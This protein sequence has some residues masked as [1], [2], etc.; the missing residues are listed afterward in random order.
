MDLEDRYSFDYLFKPNYADE[1]VKIHFNFRNGGQIPNRLY[2][3]IGKM[4]WARLNLL[5]PCQ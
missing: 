3:I 2:A 4:V 5:R 1:P